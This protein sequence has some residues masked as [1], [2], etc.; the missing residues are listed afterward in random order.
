MFGA[1]KPFGVI[2]FPF[3]PKFFSVIV[4]QQKDKNGSIEEIS[5]M[6]EVEQHLIEDVDGKYIGIMLK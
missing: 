1:I 6:P 3:S 2:N 5:H 4:V